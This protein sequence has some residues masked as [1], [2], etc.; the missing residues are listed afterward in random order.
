MATQADNQAFAALSSGMR[1][2][3][4]RQG[5][6]GFRDVQRDAIAAIMGDGADAYLISAPTASGKT[7][8]AMMPVL[9]RIQQ[10]Y[11]AKDGTDSRLSMIY[12]APL[13]ALINDQY[14]RLSV[15]GDDCGIEVHMWHGDVPAGQKSEL[16]RN[17]SGILLITPESLESFLINR[18]RWCARNMLP[19]YFVLDE[20]HAFLG[21]GRG[22]QLLSL[23]DRIDVL[24]MTAGL[25]RARRV[26]LSATLSKLDEVAGI[27]EPRGTH[28]VIDGNGGSGAD[29]EVEMSTVP[30]PPRDENGRGDRYDYGAISDIIAKESGTQKT[31]TFARSRYDVETLA[32]GLNGACG[33]LGIRSE[34]FPHHGSLSKETREA[35]EHRLVST[36]RPTMAVATVTLELGI[37]IGDIAR[38]FQVGPAGAVSSLRQRVGRSGRRD[39]RRSIMCIETAS[40]KPGEMHRD[41]VGAIAEVELMDAGWFEP[42]VRGRHD[43]SVMVSE[44]L[45]TVSQYVSAYDE[46]LREMLCVLGAFGDVSPDLFARVIQDMEY[47]ELLTRAEDGQ[48]SLGPKGDSEVRDWHFYATFQGEEAFTV[49]NGNKVVGQITPPMTSLQQLMEGGRFLLGGRCWQVVSMDVGAKSIS[50]RQSARNGKFMVPTSRGAGTQNGTIERKRLSLLCGKDSGY[51]PDYLDE[52]G[53][54]CLAE[55]REYAKRHM[56]NGLGLSIYDAGDAGSETPGEVERRI[57]R[58]WAQDQD[59]TVA[60]PLGSA[61]LDYLTALMERCGM[62]RG[63][64]ENMPLWRLIDLAGAAIEAHPALSADLPALVDDAMVADI[65]GREKYNPLLSPDTLRVAYA[66]ET[67]DPAGALAWLR[68]FGRFA[69]AL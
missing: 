61:A 5:W 40:D 12:V 15:M 26:A 22:R 3:V 4:V 38:V 62:E 60:P 43:V 9:S 68:A 50:V 65:R 24:R 2:W 8:A 30:A 69:D 39:G 27:L 52:F 32:Q 54:Q 49:K 31:L 57:S 33:R 10:A 18:G 46:D 41:L 63:G 23:M 35:L 45:S 7:E 1:K 11:D 25:G 58:G 6:P 59:V 37:D 55:A 21:N 20:F 66:D 48:L 34:A 16:M 28:V 17:H 13:K 42:P 64:F 19:D 44:I 29:V 53:A 67:F 56:L 51:V 14:R 36:E 47:A